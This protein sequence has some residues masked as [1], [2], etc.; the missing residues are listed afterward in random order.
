MKGFTLLEIIIVLGIVTILAVVTLPL[1]VNFLKQQNLSSTTST[2]IATLRQ[3]HTQAMFQKND[4]SFGV[5]FLPSSYIL[6]QGTTYN[7]REAEEDILTSIP[8]GISVSGIEEI[9]FDKRTGEPNT[10]GTIL[11]MNN[12]DNHS[13]FINEEGIIE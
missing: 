13:V 4:S 2:V 10:T 3:A 12:T 11:I 5:K 7:T 1:G 9:V 8:S 6:F